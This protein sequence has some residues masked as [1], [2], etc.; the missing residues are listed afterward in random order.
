MPPRRGGAQRGAARAGNAAAQGGRGGQNADANPVYDTSQTNYSVMVESQLTPIQA[1]GAIWI[2]AASQLVTRTAFLGWRSA[3]SFR[4]QTASDAVLTSAQAVAVFLPR[5]FIEDSPQS[6]AASDN[7][8]PL[9]FRLTATAWSRIISVYVDSDLLKEPFVDFPSFRKAM[10][11]LVLTRPQDLAIT[12]QDWSLG[13]AFAIPDGDVAEARE[14]MAALKFLSMASVSRLENRSQSSTRFGILSTLIG[15][16]GPCLTSA[17]RLDEASSLHFVAHRLKQSA[18][19]AMRDGAIAFHLPEVI[20]VALLPE[21]LQPH[22]ASVN[23]LMNEFVD[24]LLYTA[25]TA[26]RE[27]IE[28][29]RAFLLGRR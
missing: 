27:A 22:T 12:H 7:A 8:H 1:D 23:D 14:A 5:C 6:Q 26:N 15:A 19:A 20:S 18:G 16:L 24:A 25:S 29:K 13:E 9:N 11:N 28:E 10:A 4:G 21:A 17:S 2:D 3:P